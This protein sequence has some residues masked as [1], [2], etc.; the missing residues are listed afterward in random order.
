MNTLAGR[1]LVIMKNQDLSKYNITNIKL[2]HT[3]NNG[4]RFIEFDTIENSKKFFKLFSDDEIKCKYSQ[5][6]L[7]LRYKST[8]D[9]E[10]IKKII[11]ENLNSKY[12]NLN[13]LELILFQKNNIYM[14]CGFIIV[15]NI[16]DFN[17]ML[18]DNKIEIEN[19]N[20]NLFLFKYNNKSVN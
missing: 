6:K 10:N 14:N 18:S 16:L 12:E 13:I 3:S 20:E 7:F 1:T 5:Y 9:V 11:Q 15:D 8:S 17:K 4:T 19:E 2:D